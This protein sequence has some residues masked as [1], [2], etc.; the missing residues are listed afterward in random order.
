MS[1]AEAFLLMMKQGEDVTVIGSRSYGSS[2]NPKP[3]TLQNDVEV[4]IPSWK[5]M[6]VDGTCFEGRGIEQDIEVKAKS[7]AFKK[8]DPVIERAL[9]YLRE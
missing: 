9:E 8:G 6:R 3:H 7:S 2:G 5:A 4:F 1:S